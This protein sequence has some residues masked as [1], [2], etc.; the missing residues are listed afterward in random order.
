MGFG[1]AVSGSFRTLALIASGGALMLYLLACLAAVRLRSLGVRAD[2]PP[3]DFPGGT[4][5]AVLA[6]LAILWVLSSLSKAEF[7]ALA[8]TVAVAS[9][10]YAWARWRLAG[11]VTDPLA[12]LP[13]APG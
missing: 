13:D 5:V 8:V 12:K 4:A 3:L 9:A 2:G 7:G 11:R 10:I 1:F 6:A